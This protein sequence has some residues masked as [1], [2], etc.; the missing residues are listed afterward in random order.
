ML[1]LLNRKPQLSATRMPFHQIL[2]RTCL[3]AVMTVATSVTLTNAPVRAQ[4]AAKANKLTVTT[5]HQT[6]AVPNG[7]ENDIAVACPKNTLLV[8]GGG[9][10]SPNGIANAYLTSSTPYPASSTT[11][12]G[13]HIIGTNLSG[14]DLNMSV[15]ALCASVK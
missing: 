7:T 8:G 3:L 13:W 11:P 2:Q 10:M 9:E 14:T 1:N 6:V 4:T 5:V 15:Y 12:N